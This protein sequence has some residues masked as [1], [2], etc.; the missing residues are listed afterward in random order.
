MKLLQFYKW[1]INNS[2]LSMKNLA[3]PYQLKTIRDT[4]E[5]FS[6]NLL[7]EVHKADTQDQKYAITFLKEV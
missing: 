2:Q 7:V 3:P 4:T 5:N 1:S 6:E